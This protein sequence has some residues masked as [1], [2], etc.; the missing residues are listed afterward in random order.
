MFSGNIIHS[1]DYKEP[2]PYA[3]RRVL[4]VGAGA[5]GLDLATQL[6]NITAK[7]VHSHHLQYNQPDFSTTYVKKPDIRE[8]TENGVFFQ[9]GTYED[10]DD[11]IFCT[12]RH[13]WYT[14]SSVTQYHHLI[15]HELTYF[16]SIAKS[17]LLIQ[18]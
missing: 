13:F 11:V 8:F 6:S 9:D 10:I 4:L 15:G 5:S 18:N 3:N 14:K 7:L 2:E 17:Y 12:G 16:S 1:H